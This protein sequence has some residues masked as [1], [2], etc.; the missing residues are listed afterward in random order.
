MGNEKKVS[1]EELVEKY[2][3]HFDKN[4]AMKLLVKLRKAT[5]NKPKVIAGTVGGIVTSL[6]KL[7]SALDNPATPTHMKALIIGAIGYILLPLD[8]IPDITPGIGYADDLASVAGVV[9]A[10]G[11]YSDFSLEKLD[12]YIDQLEG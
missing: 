9:A 11:I 7:L 6:G 10:I 2:Q 4:M 12:A 5:R 1:E 8:L 3:Q